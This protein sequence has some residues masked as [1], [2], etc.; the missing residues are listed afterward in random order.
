[1]AAPESPAHASPTPLH[2]HTPTTHPV[3]PEPPH[4]HPRQFEAHSNFCNQSHKR[5]RRSSTGINGASS[6]DSD[7]E[8]GEQEGDG[9]W[10]NNEEEMIDSVL[11]AG[12]GPRPKVDVRDWKDLREQIKDDIVNAHKKRARLTTINQLLLLRNFSTL[13]IKGVGRMAA[14]KEIARQWHEGEGTHFARRV[15]IVARHYQLF[16]QLPMQC[17]GGCRGSSVFNDERVQSGARAWLSRLPTGEVSPQHF[18]KALTEEIL[19]CLGLN[20]N[21]VS[22][23]TA[24]R[25]LIKLGWRRTRLKKGVYMDGHERDDVVNYRNETFLPLMAKHEKCMVK[26]SEN[27]DGQ[28]ERLEPQLLPGEKQIIPIFQDESS[29]HAGEYKSNVW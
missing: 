28:F 5:Q 4:A 8:S 14:S 10:A 6:N 20:K 3:E 15:R 9:S 1:M 18:S 19:P 23:R 27:E 12:V 25:W 2:A 21:S 11:G 13:R 17:A 26:W 24:R 7:E 22:D 29:F 16:E